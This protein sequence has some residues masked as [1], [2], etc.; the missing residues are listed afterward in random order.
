VVI[1]GD[2][3]HSRVARSNIIGL[4]K[5]GA[6]VTLSGPPTMMPVQAESLGV[7]VVH[8]PEDAIKGKDVIM[9]LRIQLERQGKGRFPGLRE[10]ASFF[11]INN[12]I[13][14]NAKDD[15]I[16]MHPGPVNRGV[17]VSTD[18]IDSPFSVVLDQVANGVAV[19]MALLY[20]FI[21]GAHN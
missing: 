15:V 5:L 11:G 16:I 17:E 3:E 20:L 8:R 19:R 6:E 12:E 10:Y 21:G 13:L 2:I 14:K 1:I 4:T 18:V 7:Q 9:L